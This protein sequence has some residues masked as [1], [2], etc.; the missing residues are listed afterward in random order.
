[1]SGFLL[2]KSDKELKGAAAGIFKELYGIDPPDIGDISIPKEVI[3]IYHDTM[4]NDTTKP[5]TQPATNA[6]KGMLNKGGIDLTPANMNLQT[7]NPGGA[8]Q[9]HLD[10]AMLQKLQNAPGFVPM[11][12]GIKPMTDLQGFLE[13]ADS[14]LN[15]S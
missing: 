11:V 1:M 10:T 14:N 6:D 2:E 8:I 13:L 7:Q 4:S 15:N 3:K 12:I 9:F 5:V